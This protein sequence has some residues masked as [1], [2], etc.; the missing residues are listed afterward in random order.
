MAPSHEPDPRRGVFETLLVREGEPVALDPHLRRLAGSLRDLFGAGLPDDAPARARRECAGIEL[1]R[2]RVTAVPAGAAPRLELAAEPID[3]ALVF[4]GRG[5]R[6]RSYELRGG[7][8]PHKVV[9][10]PP[11]GRPP[12]GGPGALLLDGGEVLEAGWGNVFAV[13]GGTLWT[14]PLDGRILPGITRAAVLEIAA[15][16]ALEVEEKPL[17]PRDLATAEEVFLTGSIRC[18][19]AALELDGAPL[20]GCG[21]LSRRVAE[22]LRRRWRLP[23]T[24]DG[25]PGPATAPRPARSAR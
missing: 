16:L 7:L 20:A 22:A 12:E 8:G 19:E 11:V 2:L 24:R 14:P 3:R 15:E 23:A 1:G 9:D 6:L 5:V 4:P 10:R 13:R 17:R 25:A 21:P 18:V